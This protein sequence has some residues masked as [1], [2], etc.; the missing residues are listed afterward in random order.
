MTEL[1]DPTGHSFHTSISINTHGN[2]AGQGDGQSPHMCDRGCSRCRHEA[3]P[4]YSC[5]VVHTFPVPHLPVADAARSMHRQRC[6]KD[7]A[8][9]AGSMGAVIPAAAESPANPAAPPQEVPAL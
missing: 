2:D 6:E 9:A 3:M 5:V 1:L 7:A 8:R 4:S